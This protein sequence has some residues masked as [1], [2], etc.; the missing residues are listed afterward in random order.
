MTNRILR[1]I[2]AKT[3]AIFQFFYLLIY[4]L[5]KLYFHGLISFPLSISR[6]YSSFLLATKNYFIKLSV[7]S[8]ATIKKEYQ[9]FCR[10][11]NDYFLLKDMLPNYTFIEFAFISALR[12][13]FLNKISLVE[14]LKTAIEIQKKFDSTNLPDKILHLNNCLD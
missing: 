14:S 2:S 3:L 5:P 9:Q 6:G 13:E 7:S 1:R 10:I 4:A 8:N 11:K 12:S